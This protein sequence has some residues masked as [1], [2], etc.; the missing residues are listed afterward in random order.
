MRESIHTCSGSKLRRQRQSHQRVNNSNLGAHIIKP[1]LHLLLSQA[2]DRL[3]RKLRSRTRRSRNRNNWNSSFLPSP[4]QILPY[5]TRIGQSPPNNLR[6][7]HT[8]SSTKAN[9]EV[10]PSFSSGVNSLLNRLNRGLRQS[11]TVNLNVKTLFSQRLRRLIDKTRLL[12][13]LISYDQTMLI[14]I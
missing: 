5:V 14:H 8:T 1:V 7:I 2:Y 4:I 9:N 13:S 10:N 11:L 12:H 6:R 3:R